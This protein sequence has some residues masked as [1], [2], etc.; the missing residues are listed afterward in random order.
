MP[1]QLFRGNKRFPPLI[2][3]LQVLK[4]SKEKHMLREPELVSIFRESVRTAYAPENLEL[5]GPTIEKKKN[6][7]LVPAT[8]FGLKTNIKSDH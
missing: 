7:L 4:L 6:R 3:G 5:A 8:A 2:S 1:F